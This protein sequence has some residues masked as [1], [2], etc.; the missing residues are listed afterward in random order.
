METDFPR[1]HPQEKVRRAVALLLDS[2]WPSG[3]V[4]D[5]EGTP[6]GVFGRREVLRALSARV[7]SFFS[8]A[9]LSFACLPVEAFESEALCQ[10]WRS[11]WD[12]PVS[13]VMEPAIPQVPEDAP[14]AV[15]ARRLASGDTEVVMV[16]SNG[17]A[18]GALR[19]RDL[20]A[21]LADHPERV[22]GKRNRR[23][24]SASPEESRCRG[25]GS[26]SC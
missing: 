10:V 6:V 16:L 8:P 21:T 24:R 12:L 19:T 7:G 20:L 15:A 14:L 11:F 18:V 9:E 17:R 5:E 22:R 2:G 13:S 23:P 25:S 1:I 3:L 26:S 4:V